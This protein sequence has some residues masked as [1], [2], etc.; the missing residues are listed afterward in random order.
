MKKI[1]LVS[2]K[3]FTVFDSE[4]PIPHSG[5]VLI[6]IGKVGICG[7]DIHLFRDGA[8]GNLRMNNSLVIGH[9]CMGVV[10]EV[11][12]GVPQ[13]WVGQRVAIEP[14][15]TCGKCEMCKKGYCNLCPHN[16]FLGLPPYEG[17][18]QEF[19]T[20]PIEFI[21][22]VSDKISDG[23]AVVLEPMAVA[24]HGARLMHLN[25]GETVVILGTGVLGLCVLNIVKLYQGVHII[26]VDLLENRLQLAKKLGAD[27]VVKAKVGDR[28]EVINEI[29]SL[30]NG[31]GAE[32]VFECSGSEDTLWNA[33]EVAAPAGHVAIIGTNPHD[34]VTFGSGS[35]RRKGLTIR[36]VRRS[37]HTLSPCIKL[38][39]AGLIKPDLLVTHVFK[40]S[41]T[42]KAFET[43]FDYKDGV[44]KALIDVTNF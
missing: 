31:I 22:P 36:F 10:A 1:V 44:V 11:G 25:P 40:G 4:K 38:A 35:S 2:P 18:L 28:K 23:A 43:V 3:H 41:E 29:L 24:F 6:Q 9:E 26:C 17:A 15:V 21:E 33:C 14:A 7:S 27:S 5:E 30:T 39:E 8:I 16:K 12:Q 19:I 32:K 34:N 42:Q 37:L 20:H 13:K